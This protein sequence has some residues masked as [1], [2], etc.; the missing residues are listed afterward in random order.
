MLLFYLIEI[1]LCYY[2][3][4][5]CSSRIPPF[6]THYLHT[7]ISGMSSNEATFYDKHYGR[8]LSKEGIVDGE[9]AALLSVILFGMI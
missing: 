9:F 5:R 3:V 1:V 7:Q 8:S 2:C 4:W 6:S